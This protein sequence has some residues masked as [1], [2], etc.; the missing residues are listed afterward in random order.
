MQEFLKSPFQILHFSYN[1]LMTLLMM[2]AQPPFLQWE[3]G[4]GIF[5]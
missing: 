1:T 3:G 2:N 4:V 5:E